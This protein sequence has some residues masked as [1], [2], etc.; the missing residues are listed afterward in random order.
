MAPGEVGSETR[1]TIL[2][3]PT[4]G[5]SIIIVSYN[6][7]GRL[8]ACLQSLERSR[9]VPD[10]ETFVVD[11]ASADGSADMV[12]SE[13]PSVRLIRS[14]INGGYA[15]ANNLAL[16]QARGRLILLLNPDTEVEPHAIAALS[17]DLERHPEVAAVGPK[18]VRADGSLDLACRRS[19][20]SPAVAFYRMVGLSRLFPHSRRFG[21]YNLTYL[22]PD[23]ETE[24]DGL[25]GACMLIRR[26]A[27]EQVGLLDERFFM[28]GED[29]DWAYRMKESGWHIRYNPKVAILHH[30]G[31]SSR[32]NSER[33]TVA[34][35]RAMHL[36]YAK[37][38]RATTFFA[39][40][41]I[42]I[43]GIY[44]RLAWA[45][46]RNALRAP[47]QRRVST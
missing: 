34:F 24:V 14:P 17:S 19:F 43:A 38:Y 6:T 39:L 15:Y 27:I 35:Y 36:F 2:G 44:A 18:L 25:A 21:R 46:F 29:L 45:L 28:Y 10:S 3:P 7:V 23:L 30:K 42:I 9:G 16:R 32:Q 31:E 13:F 40:D 37:H 1:G 26:A 41:W 33:A 4:L 12:A 11:N 8:R 5:L 47:G 20:P 22:D